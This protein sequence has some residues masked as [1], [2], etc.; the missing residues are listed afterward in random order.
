LGSVLLLYCTGTIQYFCTR[1]RFVY[2]CLFH[3]VIELHIANSLNFVRKTRI[4]FLSS[5]QIHVGFF[6][7]YKYSFLS[8]GMFLKA[9]YRSK[10]CV[11]KFTQ[12]ES[13]WATIWR[14]AIF[15]TKFRNQIAFLRISHILL[16]LDFPLSFKLINLQIR[17][18]DQLFHR[19][20]KLTHYHICFS[21]LQFLKSTVAT[22][23]H[24]C[25]FFDL[26]SAPLQISF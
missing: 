10:F 11:Y 23:Y 12:T 19:N 17:K 16:F 5:F 1:A 18:S 3:W 2:F 24:V 14:T 9:G 8:R 22:G 21:F 25:P 15:T 26:K 6:V 13:D 20:G 4:I 7:F